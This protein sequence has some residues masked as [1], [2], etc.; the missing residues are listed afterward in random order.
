MILVTGATVNPKDP[1]RE[2]VDERE[3]EAEVAPAAPSE[4]GI[5]I[6]LRI[7]TNREGV[8]IKAEARFEPG[9]DTIR[10]KVDGKWVTYPLSDLSESDRSELAKVTEAFVK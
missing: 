7:W 2:I 3:T 4:P 10:L 5:L 6:P 9:S 8:A 1:D